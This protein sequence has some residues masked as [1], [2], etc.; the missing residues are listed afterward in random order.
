[1]PIS[2]YS[3]L[4]QEYISAHYLEVESSEMR[5]SK[6]SEISMMPQEQIYMWKKSCVVAC[7]LQPTKQLSA[8]SSGMC[9]AA[10]YCVIL[11]KINNSGAKKN[12]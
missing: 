7:L 11:P 3:V 4:R 5:W 6:V 1:M 10:L 8:T 9:C 2:G 12:P